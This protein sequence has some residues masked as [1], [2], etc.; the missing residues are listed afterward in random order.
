MPPLK[1]KNTTPPILGKEL[2]RIHNRLDELDIAASRRSGGESSW[3]LSPH[4]PGAVAGIQAG[5]ATTGAD[6]K[7][8]VTFPTPF[9]SGVLPVIVVSCL[10][11]GEDQLVA[12]VE[13]RSETQCVISV[14][15]IKSQGTAGLY[16]GMGEAHSHAPGTFS[17]TVPAGTDGSSGTFGV[18]GVS[19]SESSHRHPAPADNVPHSHGRELVSGAMVFWI[20]MP[21]S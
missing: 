14:G 7:V 1:W 20:A 15:K 4:I 8:T 11:I 3:G 6:G 2:A 17:V 21:P 5:V 13:S 19:A 12:A 9:Q 18:A 10:N 16:T